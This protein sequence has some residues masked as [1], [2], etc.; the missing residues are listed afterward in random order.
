MKTTDQFHHKYLINQTVEADNKESPIS[1]KVN[2]SKVTYQSKATLHTEPTVATKRSQLLPTIPQEHVVRDETE[3]DSDAL[4]LR[5]A[6]T[7]ALAG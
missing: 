5:P 1:M 7:M 6:H 2:I 4:Q 3:G